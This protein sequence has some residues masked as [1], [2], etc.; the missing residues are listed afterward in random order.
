KL[1]NL[2]TLYISNNQIGAG[3]A[4]AIAKLNNL[5][6]L[7]IS[8][9]QISSPQFFKVLLANATELDHIISHGNP[10]RGLPSEIQDD[11]PALRSWFQ[12]LDA[13]KEP[14]YTSDYKILLCGN[15]GVGKST[16]LDR[17]Q[18]KTFDP[19]KKSTHGVRIEEIALN[20][21]TRSYVWDFGGQEIYHSTHRLFLKGDAVALVVWDQT[22]E[23]QTVLSNRL[24]P[25][26]HYYNRTL[27]Y[28]LRTLQYNGG[29]HQIVL[30]QNKL[31]EDG[32]EAQQFNLPNW[33]QLRNNTFSAASADDFEV[34]ILRRHLLAAAK[35]LRNW[36]MQ[37]PRSWWGVRQEI[38]DAAQD[39][40]TK[41]WTR[42]YF[43]ERCAFH[44][45]A[46]NTVNSLLNYLHD[47]GIL[48]RDNQ[49]FPDEI[50]INQQWA[51]DAIYTVLDPEQKFYKKLE[52]KGTFTGSD[53]FAEWEKEGYA[54]N[55][56]ALFL[57]LMVAAHLCFSINRK[58]NTPLVEQVFL[59]P[60]LLRKQ[61]HNLIYRFWDK[62]AVEQVRF[63]RYQHKH[64]DFYTIQR[65]ITE[66]GKKT[67]LENIWRNGLD[68]S[69]ANSYA[70]VQ[71][72]IPKGTIL[73]KTHGPEASYL[74]D[75]IRNQFRNIHGERPVEL[76]VSINGVDFVSTEEIEKQ[77]KLPDA[78][79]AL[80]I[81]ERTAVPLQ[82]LLWV[83]QR[84]EEANLDQKLPDV[85]QDAAM[86]QAKR[87]G[88]RIFISYAKED[89]TLVDAFVDLLSTYERNK[90]IQ[91]YYDKEI[92][93]RSGWDEQLQTEMREAEAF[94]V[95][96]STDYFANRKE[97]I[98][99]EEV[100]LMY[101]RHQEEKIP[102]FPILVNRP[103]LLPFGGSV[104]G[105]ISLLGKDLCLRDDDDPRCLNKSMAAAQKI[106]EQLGVS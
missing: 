63:L 46:D 81:D 91:I 90:K 14:L 40:K 51:L 41:K 68:L 12:E 3:G 22:T 32:H 43:K 33:E 16:I 53:I 73:V 103:A 19:E 92:H 80:A 45:V 82:P 100:P 56:R 37:V 6:T 24:R 55:D 72:D 99:D 78:K 87:A 20:E 106:L 21:H 83:L 44:E 34:D 96:A 10:V 64:L 9:N 104:L 39:E 35:N 36:K 77:Q 29:E 57:N 52:E 86:A 2:T 59:H 61:A 4:T 8:N 13:D 93:H 47:S 31:D 30:L 89:K 62:I 85:K 17:L 79:S 23:K 1:N 69:W 48:F 66:L 5:T 97:Y 38:L 74:M 98:L 71:A 101:E 49:L 25:G 102:V 88:Q 95:F 26:D 50:I 7:Y 67:E 27:A 105:S 75:G 28:W 15:S 18:G 58:E 11:I 94:V 65:F 84:D 70:Y 42:N 60:A 76:Q 54:A